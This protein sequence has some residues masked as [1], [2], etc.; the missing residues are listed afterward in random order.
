MTVNK[1]P[2]QTAGK[3]QVRLTGDYYVING[4]VNET[5]ELGVKEALKGQSSQ[6]CCSI[7]LTTYGG[8]GDVAYK[9]GRLLQRHYKKVRFLINSECKSAGTILCLAGHELFMSETGELGPLDVQ[10]IDGIKSSRNS[11]LDFNSSLSIARREVI[12][13]FLES[14]K[15]MSRL[16]VSRS[17]AIKSAGKIAQS[18]ASS[19][20]AQIDP[21]QI[22][23]TQRSIAI[24]LDYGVRLATSSQSI[25]PENLKKLITGYSSHGFCIDREEATGLFKIVH[26]L[27]DDKEIMSILEELGGSVNEVND[28]NTCNVLKVNRNA[29]CEQPSKVKKDTDSSASGTP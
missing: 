16:K 21:I 4:P 11:G 5:M 14:F 2:K 8:S 9:V 18:I 19:L 3:E 13:S 7:F 23:A 25:T 26:K 1:N 24:A 17:H 20:Y 22:A 10:I 12:K 6:D 15:E 27:E 28:S 29:T